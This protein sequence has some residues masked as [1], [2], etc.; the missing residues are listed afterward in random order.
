MSSGYLPGFLGTIC[1]Y[2]LI[3]PA[4][5][6]ETNELPSIVQKYATTAKLAEEAGW[7][8][9]QIHAAHGYLIAQFLSP[10]ANQRTDKYGGS[11]EG[12]KKLLLEVIAAI[13][14]VTSPSFVVGIK[15]NTKDR[16]TEGAERETEC[17]HLIQE[18]CGME[19]LDFIE[20]SG[21]GFEDAMF[22]TT[23]DSAATG[24]FGSFAERLK[25]QLQFTEKSP[26]IVLTGGFRTKAGMQQALKQHLCDMIGLGR[27]VITYPQFSTKLLASSNDDVQSTCS[28]LQA[29]IF[30]EI[31]DAA[32]NSLWYQRQL[33]RI[34]VGLNPNPNLSYLYTLAVSFFLAYIWDFD[35]GGHALYKKNSTGTN[36]DS[37][38][39][40]KE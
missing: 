20:L 13:R 21:G 11:A 38:K 23:T 19:Q 6:L 36:T 7:D 8:G 30:G 16:A 28:T 15:V 37:N 35:F 1:G 33:H 34:S 12:R 25:S 29:P 26:K 40:K 32:L 17:L 14:K 5:A 24:T 10:S 2:L 27:P 18:L 3:R 39:N 22:V 9:V 31:L 4:R